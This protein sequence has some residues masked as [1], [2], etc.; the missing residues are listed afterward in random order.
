[1]TG[2]QALHDHRS[3]ASE[4]SRPAIYGG[5]ATFDQGLIGEPPK[6]R[7]PLFITFGYYISFA[8]YIWCSYYISYWISEPFITSRKTLLH[9]MCY[10]IWEIRGSAS[11]Q[12]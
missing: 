6:G 7:P 10:Y 11:V 2:S 5:R 9:F 1:M 12:N 3:E 4:G 8:S